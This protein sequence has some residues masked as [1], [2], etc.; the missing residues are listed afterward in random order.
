MPLVLLLPPSER[1]HPGG[2]GAW[3]PDGGRVPGL[4]PR[5]AE[6]A[7]ALARLRG[8]AALAVTKLR[9]EAAEA[10]AVANAATVGSPTLPAGAR[11]GGVVWEHLD[12]AS[13]TGPGRR[14]AA[15]V[16]VVSALGGLWAL[17]DPVPAYKLGMA[18]NLPGLGGLTGWWAPHLRAA[19]A[20][21]AGRGPVVDLLPAEHRRAVPLDGLGAR[22]VRVDFTTAGGAGAA[23]HAAKAAKG[24]LARHL[25][26]EGGDPSAAAD[27]WTWAG[28]A[29][30]ADRTRVVVTAPG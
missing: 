5:R 15:S 20:G 6:V 4:G 22:V 14:R 21:L 24:R 26:E 29:A 11:Y 10:A 25:L 16:L 19:L 30:A 2:T 9:G 13:L 7:A 23:G 17:G 8:P 28:W 27:G 3:R 18:A 12:A 1:K